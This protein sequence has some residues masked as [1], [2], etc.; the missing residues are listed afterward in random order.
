MKPI[1]KEL[2]KAILK[3]PHARAEIA[4][5]ENSGERTSIIVRLGEVLGLPVSREAV[6]RFLAPPPDG[7][8]SDLELEM[9]VGGK[10]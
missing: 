8:L 10:N 1:E 6:E 9:V 7:E 5:A 4:G 2:C 3:D